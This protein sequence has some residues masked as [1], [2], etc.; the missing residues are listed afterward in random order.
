LEMFTAMCS[1]R[2]THPILLIRSAVTAPMWLSPL[3]SQKLAVGECDF[4]CCE[5]NHKD[6]Q[7]SR[8]CVVKV[9]SR[10]L[11]Q[12]VKYL[13]ENKDTIVLG[14]LM[15]VQHC[16]FLRGFQSVSSDMNIIHDIVTWKKY[17][18]WRHET[19]DGEWF[20][21]GGI[22][23]L[24]YAVAASNE[25]L[26]RSLL[27][28]VCC[29]LSLSL[30]LHTH[31]H[32]TQIQTITDKEKRHQRL[33]SSVPSSGYPEIGITSKMNSLCVAMFMASSKIVMMLLDAGLNPYNCADG[34]GID[35]FMFACTSAQIENVRS[36]LQYTKTWDVNRR[37]TFNGS[38]ALHTVLYMCSS[39]RTEEIVGILIKEGNSRVDMV[40]DR[41]SSILMNTVENEDVDPSVLGR[42]LRHVKNVNRSRQ[43]RTLKW[44]LIDNAVRRIKSKEGDLF[45]FLARESGATALHAA[46]GFY[47]M[48]L[49]HHYTLIS[50]SLILT[51]RLKSNSKYIQVSRGDTHIVELL[52][53]AGANPSFKNNLGQSA[54]MM[55][56][57]F[58]ELQ[59][60]LQKRERKMKF[61]GAIQNKTTAVEALGKRLST[62]TP[63][64]HEMWLIS[65][66]TLLMLY[67]TEGKGQVM[68]VHQELK[69]QGFL[70]NWRD[71]PSDAE[72]VFVS[73][74]W[75]SWAHPDPQGR[76]LRVLC[77]VLERL[78]EGK[79]AT[80]MDP[81]HTIMYKHKFKTKGKEWKEML[82]RTYL[83]VD[84]FSMPQP[85]TYF[86]FCSY[87][88]FVFLFFFLSLSISPSLSSYA[89]SISH[90]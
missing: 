47:Y 74:E 31:T 75:L 42:I 63:I 46:V 81:M 11:K 30:L 72:I 7:C 32:T 73:H 5:R 39:K 68:E 90:Q 88:H 58:P 4:T 62:A 45:H 10:L 76:Q 53:S 43:P 70:M 57:S 48:V 40:N 54:V 67:G 61:R 56:K 26:V 52:L 2:K 69:K 1:R 13:F 49:N 37:N 16:W 71:T 77:R 65:L 35:P 33:L 55:S 22:S 38:T 17:L 23:V 28:L 21:R 18:T 36:W 82:R 89:H 29:F 66:E 24:F 80:E 15:L 44:H 6:M 8:K 34:A 20:D 9:M 12:Y 87:F 51:I 59:C 78:K 50:S 84:W 3:E 25:A 64:Q 85:G 14:R 27:V 79:L 86:L 19:D 60:M 83:W 41:G